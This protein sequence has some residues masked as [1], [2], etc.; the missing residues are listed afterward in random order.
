MIFSK[1]RYAFVCE[2][3]RR[4]RAKDPPKALAAGPRAGFPLSG[5]ML[6]AIRGAR[7]DPHEHPSRHKK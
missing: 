1:S 2:G 3:L 7:R 6:Y 5:L 4:T